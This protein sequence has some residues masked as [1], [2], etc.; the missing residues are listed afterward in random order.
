MNS[1]KIEGT[2]SKEKRH[3][4]REIILI[5]V[6]FAFF[7]LFFYF[8]TQIFSLGFRIP[9]TRN[10]L[11]VSLI[12]L[13]ILFLYLV[14]RILRNIVK[15]I[16]ERRKKVLGSKLRTKLVLAFILFSFVPTLLLFSIAT[17]VITK[18]IESWFSVQVEGSLQESL[19]VAQLYYENTS[20]NALYY[21]RQIS[22]HLI[23]EKL[24]DKQKQTQL[25]DFLRE[26]RVEYNLEVVEVISSQFP[27]P[28]QVH[29]PVLPPGAIPPMETKILD[30]A[31]RGKEVWKN[32]SVGQGD[33][34][35]A[36]VPIS[37]PQNPREV[38]GV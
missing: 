13:I 16:L 34:I 8:R 14:F 27:K 2:K 15:L 7:A 11:V 6:F 17:G 20:N 30:E 37:S 23:R 29:G 24:L 36:V 10:I 1:K 25:T 19:V 9:V 5:L 18:S 32:Q 4:R 26:K 3:R 35:R 12:L 21:A 31:L 28:V 22:G 33:L 38:L